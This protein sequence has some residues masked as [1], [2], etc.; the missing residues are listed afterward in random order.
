MKFV[1]FGTGCTGVQTALELEAGGMQRR[2]LAP[3]FYPVLSSPWLLD[4]PCWAVGATEL[5]RSL[6]HSA[7]PDPGAG[8]R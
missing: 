5:A 1:V 4:L 6:R 2:D 7:A 3:K 8:G